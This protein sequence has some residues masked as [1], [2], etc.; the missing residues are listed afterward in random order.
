MISRWAAP[1][2]LFQ[3]HLSSIIRCYC[4]PPSDTVCLFTLGFLW[5]HTFTSISHF[6]LFH[7]KQLSPCVVLLVRTH[8][9]WEGFPHL[10][11]KSMRCSNLSFGGEQV[12]WKVCTFSIKTWSKLTISHQ[13]HLFLSLVKW[14]NPEESIYKLGHINANLHHGFISGMCVGTWEEGERW[15]I[16]EF[17]ESSFKVILCVGKLVR[18]LIFNNKQSYHVTFISHLM[19]RA[20]VTENFFYLL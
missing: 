20:C 5:G 4:W 8:F 9:W 11:I 10:D 6:Y 17:Q 1:L 15:S 18:S 16:L 12:I 7:S 19:P 14:T 2:N 3:H 13:P